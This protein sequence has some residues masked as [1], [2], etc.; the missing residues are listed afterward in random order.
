MRPEFRF[1]E[2]TRHRRAQDATTHLAT[3]RDDKDTTFASSTRAADKGSKGAMRLLLRH[4]VQ[5]EASFNR[6]P[7]AF[8]PLGIGP[9]IAGRPIERQRRQWA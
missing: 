5:V 1:I 9:I 2:P 4:P 8:Q 3:P 7:A 6:M